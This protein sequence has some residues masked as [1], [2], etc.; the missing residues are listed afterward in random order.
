MKE[1][2]I[3]QAAKLTSPHL[4]AAIVTKNSDGKVNI[5]GASW[6]SFVSFRNQ[7]M[8]FC[9]SASGYTGGIVKE[10]GKASLCFITQAAAEQVFKCCKVSGHNTDKIKEFGISLVQP[11]GFDVPVPEGSGVAFS[12]ELDQA[13]LSGDH[14]IYICSIKK[15]VQLSDEPILMAFDGYSRIGTI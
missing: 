7:K 9:T 3:G 6:L 13:V 15:V 10:T 14:N 4:F 11:E 5:M 1:I 2:T 12:L 8:L